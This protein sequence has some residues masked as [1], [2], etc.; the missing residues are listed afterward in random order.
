MDTISVAVADEHD[1]IRLG[2]RALLGSEA[3]IRVVGEAADGLEAVKIVEQAR[4]DVLLLNISLPALNGFEVLRRVVRLSPR[5][6]VLMMSAHA[7]ETDA[8]QALRAGACGYVPKRA[9][10][11][12]I[13]EAI[14]SVAA[15]NRYL[16]PPL[17][18]LAIEAYLERADDAGFDVLRTLTQREREVLQLVAEGK[19]NAEVAERLS[20]GVRT[21]ESHRAKAMRKIG[22]RTQTDLVIFAIRRGLLSLD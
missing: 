14:R 21:V 2:I 3:G 5:T 10:G 1:V 13:V 12:T 18:E 11:A 7:A 19:S 16:S 4:P 6:A 15:G 9:R 8:V 22:A 20:I 17:S